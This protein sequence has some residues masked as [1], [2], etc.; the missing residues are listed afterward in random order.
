MRN[1]FRMSSMTIKARLVFLGVIAALGFASLVTVGWY[2]GSQTIISVQQAEKLRNDIGVIN[3]MRLANIEMVL[4]AMDTI[5]DKAEGQVMP[6]RREIIE[7]SIELIRN[8]TPALVTMS[9]FLGRKDLTATMA[10]DLAEVE[11]AIAVDLPK[12]ISTNAS[13]D[14]FAALD[15]AIDGGGERLNQSLTTLAEIGNEAVEQQ[16]RGVETTAAWAEYWLIG[17][18]G[19]FMVL[20][21]IITTFIVRYVSFALSRFGKDMQSIASGNLD[22][23]IEAENRTDE[24]GRMA[25]SLVVFRDAAVEKAELQR[26][27]DENRSLS[28]RE[29]AERER[30]KEED[31]RRMQAA[32]DALAGGL[33]RLADGDLSV[34]LDAPFMQELEKLR[35]D[36]NTSAEKLSKTLGEVKDNISSIRGDANEMRAGADD[37]S[38]R[39]E[40]QAASLEETSAALEQITA[41]VRSSSERASDATRMA[42]ETRDATDRSGKV[43]ADAIDAMGRIETASGKIST[44]IN[45]I[46]EIAFQTNLLALNAGVEAARAGDA[47]KGFAVVAQEVRE[48]AQRSADAAR[49]IKGLIQNSGSEVAN[50]VSLVSASGEALREIEKKV[51]A[52]NEHISSI[53][54]AAREQA[55]G[56]QEINIAVSQMDQMTQQNAAMV[57]ETTAVTHR[58]SGETESLADLIGQFRISATAAQ[59]SPRT[60][61]KNAVPVASPAR[62]IVNKVVSAFGG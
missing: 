3:E 45:V 36:F 43:V 47:G 31:A 61:E 20:I 19:S 54:T 2:S 9:E 57:E 48:L 8:N 22:T 44:I 29:R 55:T 62:G 38:R 15:D 50:G 14:Q 42:G 56:L 13:E 39:T 28:E 12:L 6:E 27:A 51:A 40:Q 24:V 5:I 11:K 53:A 16:L 23:E 10:E 25:K 21:G 33:I 46:D 4:A 34:R 30:I 26:Q 32:V 7:A 52:I 49:E 35:T 41:T 58:L 17:L 37:L 18:A 60:A 1:F 59:N